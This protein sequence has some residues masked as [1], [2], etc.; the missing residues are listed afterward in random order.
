MDN[1]ANPGDQGYQTIQYKHWRL[2]WEQMQKDGYKA[3]EPVCKCDCK[4]CKDEPPGAGS[5]DNKVDVNKEIDFYRSQIEYLNNGGDLD[6]NSWADIAL[7]II[8]WHKPSLGLIQKCSDIE[9]CKNLVKQWA[10]ID[11]STF[12]PDII[13]NHQQ[14]IS[15]MACAALYGH[16]SI[17]KEVKSMF[18]KYL[19]TFYERKIFELKK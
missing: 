14:A 1:K 7:G 4:E 2:K 13:D 18:I 15:D 9:H 19:R 10:A 6:K 3:E 16:S 11:L 5:N 8:I 17:V 12:C